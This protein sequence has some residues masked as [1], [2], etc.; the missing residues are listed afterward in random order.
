R[1]DKYFQRVVIVFGI[2]VVLACSSISISDGG[3]P[4]PSAVQTEIA[5]GIMSTNLANNQMT[6]Q[7]LQVQMTQQAAYVP[8]TQTGEPPQAPTQNI[9]PSPEPTK[10]EV[11]TPVALVLEIMKSVSTF[12]CYQSPYELTITVRVSDI[13][14]GM[15]VYYH[16]RDKQSGVKSDGQA[17]DLHRRLSN[18]TR[19]ATIIGGGSSQQNLQFPPLMGESYFVYQ[20]ISDDGSYRSPTYSDI[21]FFPC[22]Q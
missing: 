4:D 21:T 22:G 17:I 2:S 16:I 13:N 11:P 20:I 14:R 7:A 12:Y 1:K 9:P 18:D 10:T 15:A 3:K 8:P 19:T 6:L 5:F